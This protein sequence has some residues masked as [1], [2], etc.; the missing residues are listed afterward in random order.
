MFEC[1]LVILCHF[2]HG[3]FGNMVFSIQTE[4]RLHNY[5]INY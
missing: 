4:I 5:Q 3:S 1:V 2:A